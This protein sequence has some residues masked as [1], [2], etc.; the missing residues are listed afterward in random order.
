MRVAS[1]FLPM[2]CMNCRIAHLC[3]RIRVFS[4]KV[5]SSDEASEATRALL[6]IILQNFIILFLNILLSQK[7]FVS[8]QSKSCAHESARAKQN[9]E[10][11]ENSQR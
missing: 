5:D 6:E 7:F 1:L 10:Y 2:N 3:G 8:L 11:T 4:H 9:R